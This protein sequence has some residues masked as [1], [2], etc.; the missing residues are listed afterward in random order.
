MTRGMK[1]RPSSGSVAIF[2]SSTFRLTS[3]LAV[4]SSGAAAV[5]STDW[6]GWPTSSF[7]S[8]AVRSPSRRVMPDC[9]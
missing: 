7:T 4:C 9:R 1:L 5:T 2:F 8:I 3:P 6:D